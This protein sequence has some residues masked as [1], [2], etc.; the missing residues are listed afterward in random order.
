MA[1]DADKELEALMANV[2]A[3]DKKSEQQVHFVNDEVV[4]DTKK[5]DTEYYSGEVYFAARKPALLAPV[6]VRI[7][8]ITVFDLK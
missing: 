7:S 4:S 8:D 6:Y 3:E 5:D 1:F 2:N